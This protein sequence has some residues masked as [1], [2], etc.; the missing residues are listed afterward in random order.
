MSSPKSLVIGKWRVP[1]PSMFKPLV[2]PYKM[3]FDVG[4][5]SVKLDLLLDMEQV[6]PESMQIGFPP[7][8]KFIRQWLV[9][10]KDCQ[11]HK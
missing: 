11:A 2:I 3:V 1:L 8:L 7:G 10:C 5:K 6:A 9:L 4:L